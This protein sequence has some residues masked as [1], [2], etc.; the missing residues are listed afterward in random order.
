[1]SKNREVES[2]MSNN[3]NKLC[4]G[5]EIIGTINASTDFRIDGNVEGNINCKGKIVVGEKALIKGDIVTKNMDVIGN[6]SGTITVG[7]LLCLKSTAVVEGNILTK[8]IMIEVGAVFNGNVKMSENV[9][10]AD[11]TPQN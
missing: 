5:T 3:F 4:H 2:Q 11:F 6:I 10:E 7:D 9:P 8:K 1:M